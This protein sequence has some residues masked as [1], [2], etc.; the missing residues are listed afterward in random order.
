MRNLLIF[1]VVFFAPLCLAES[2]TKTN[3]CSEQ[4]AAKLVSLQ[5]QLFFDTSGKGHW[6]V[7]QLD[8]TF[9]EGSR[10]RVET[11][12]RASLLLPNGITL[13][14][15]EGTVMSLNGIAPSQPTLLDLLRGFVHFISRTP[16]QLQITTP[17]ANAGPEGTE[18]ALRAD[19]SSAALWV[20]E[21]SVR[22]FN[23]K[24]GLRLKPGDAARA[25]MGQAPL[26]KI[27]I[28][29][30]DAVNW[31]LYYP[32]LLPYPDSATPIVEPLRHAIQEYR[33]GRIDS[34]L[35][36]LDALPSAQHTPYFFKV[37]GA[38]R[39]TA[40]Q[41][42]AALRDIQS[43][44]ANNPDDAEALAL[45][46]ALVL[47]QNRKNDAQTLAEQAIAAS[48][49][50]ANAHTA[51]SYAQQAHFELEAAL[52][53]AEH[54]SELAPHDAMTWARQAELELS[55]G[56]LKA[57]HNSAQRAFEL[58][59]KLERT[60]TVMG[61]SHLFGLDFDQARQNFESAVRLD[62]T[63]PLARLGLGLT[64]IR[65]GDLEAGRQDLEIAAILDPNNS[66]IRSY[67]GKA[68][69]EEKR[70]RLAG[71]Q[72]DL[73]KQRDRNDP[74]PYFYD[75][76]RKQTTNRPIEALHDL[77]KAI[78][79]NHNRGVYR[80]KLQLD[81]DLAARS[82]S[83]GRIYN[84][85]G[86]QWRGLVQG[87][88]SVNDDP[89]NYSAHRLLADNYAAFPRH[90]ISRV[91]E[92]LQSQ[93]LQPANMT[94]IQPQLSDSNPLIFEGLGP[95]SQSF[96]E[97]NPLYSRNRLALQLSGIFG[98]NDTWGN[99]A[100]HSGIWNRLSY[101]LGQMHYSSNGFRANN[102]V[103]TNLY[104]GFGQ[105]QIN[106]STSLQFEY[107]DSQTRSGDLSSQFFEADVDKAL[108]QKSHTATARAG[109]HYKLNTNNDFLLSFT[110]LKREISTDSHHEFLDNFGFQ[111]NNT[112]YNRKNTEAF[113]LESQYIKRF[114]K[115]N[116]ILGFGYLG[117]NEQ[118]HNTTEFNSSIFGFDLPCACS[119]KT[120]DIGGSF[121]NS[122]LYSNINVL[123]S[124]PATL[125]LS[126]DSMDNQAIGTLNKI[127]P[128]VGMKWH[129]APGSTLRA[130]YFTSVKRP[131]ISDQTIEPTQVA[132]FNQFFDDI[133]GSFAK[134]YGVGIDHKLS[135][136][137]FIGAEVSW[138]DIKVPVN[139]F[140]KKSQ[141]EERE[142][143]YVYWAL[144]DH[145]SV[146]F[147][148]NYEKIRRE[149][150]N[151]TDLTPSNIETLRIPLS[152]NYF[153]TNGIFTKLTATHV[154]QSIEKQS[155]L[156]IAGANIATQQGNNN[157]WTVDAQMG[158]RL[159][160]RWGI[161]SVG[162]KNLLDE[163]LNY[164]EFYFQTG[165]NRQTPSAFQPGRYI[166]S[167]ITIAFN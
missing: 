2:D 45:K 115:F 6:Q 118:L 83:L 51:L 78:E 91:S 167:Q 121:I 36:I 29:P 135:K 163:K 32:A 77:Q 70:D 164:Q 31:A 67:L 9:C 116:Y 151:T 20:Y 103:E 37:R 72:L 54:A 100:I 5:G 56:Q 66:L 154:Y 38:I 101:S 147:D 114:Q 43:L 134:R 1:F 127:N 76:I 165:V 132:G 90:E 71:D 104:S 80:S 21:G 17:I 85:L 130:A 64:K 159:P 146:N 63:S 145:L 57:S 94:P 65:N 96:T 60:Q 88:N 125:G 129:Y 97:F 110:H 111:Q 153:L 128:K 58:D 102:D 35:E 23:S 166:Y 28:N 139:E 119:N 50:S 126:F 92:L 79:L 33:Q 89:T 98:G 19:A 10:V 156:K 107:R 106:P 160:K 117:H 131:L 13:R 11:Y 41:T 46:S 47:T 84:N 93:L 152:I 87:W 138:R 143:A 24:G 136:D 74:T 140:T 158:Y 48:P 124:L 137:I 25:E 113:N 157:F 73:A 12:S 155:G 68:Y 55:L 18:F 109:L 149:L 99:E 34:A 108:R 161:I 27:D 3:H 120:T 162:V 15:G 49:Q 75:A 133:T 95:T 22:F 59:P 142:R 123:D 144:N 86:F 112:E 8:Q 81:E 82:A 16:K 53:S 44:L 148:V 30:A 14:L 39:L 122:Y 150:F 7:A 42:D 4:V 69:Y 105:Y 62:S 52:A 26:A 61:F 40:G 141:R